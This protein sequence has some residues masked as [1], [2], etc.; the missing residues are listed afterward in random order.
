MT[1]A[2]LLAAVTLL[3]ACGCKESTGVQSKPDSTGVTSDLTSI[4]GTV[5][6]DIAVAPI[7]IY[8]LDGTD[9]RVNVVGEKAQQL[10]SLD[11]AQVQLRGNWISKVP[12]PLIHGSIGPRF[13]IT[14]FVVLA[15]GGRQAM[16]GVLGQ[17]E[18]KYYLR[19]TAGNAYW[20][21]DPPARFADYLGKRIWVTGWLENST[22]TCGVIG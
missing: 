6:A 12:P 4:T 8:L 16:D 19:L 7:Q 11:G 10:A 3:I 9:Q 14:E 5:V 15:V 20:F 2:Q 1:R 21:K 22:L 13:A 17:N 18:G